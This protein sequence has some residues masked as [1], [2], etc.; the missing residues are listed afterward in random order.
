MSNGREWLKMR[1]AGFTREAGTGQPILLLGAEKEQ[2]MFTLWLGEHE[3]GTIARLCT[4][5]STDVPRLAELLPLALS[6]FDIRHLR[7]EI[8]DL[9]GNSYITR[10]L[11]KQGNEYV[12]VSCRPEDGIALALAG[13]AG[14]FLDRSLFEAH[15]RTMIDDEGFTP[16]D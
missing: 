13:K 15:K 12:A 11:L 6:G 16:K 10:I 9:D 4:G 2:G 8:T 14:I 7:T 5:D 1:V 3:A